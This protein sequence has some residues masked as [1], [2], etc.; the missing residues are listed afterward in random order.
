LSFS[1]ALES[2]IDPVLLSTDFR[3]SETSHIMELSGLLT[4]STEAEA[5]DGAMDKTEK[6]G[7]P[8]EFLD[9]LLA[10]GLIGNPEPKGCIVVYSYMYIISV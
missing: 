9:S 4:L 2:A 8:N 7:M 5:C 6:G 3:A 10:R 1:V